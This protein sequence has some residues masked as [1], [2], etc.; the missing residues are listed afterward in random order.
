MR[1]DFNND[2]NVSIDDMRKGLYELYEFLKNFDYI[3]ATTRIRS[4]VYEE[5]KRYIRS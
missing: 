5:A 2:G 1:L 3:E 4:S